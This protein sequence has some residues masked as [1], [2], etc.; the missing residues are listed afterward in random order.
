MVSR[1][2]RPGE[3]ISRRAVLTL[4][5]GDA[6]LELPEPLSAESVRDLDEWL[7]LVLRRYR[8]PGPVQGDEGWT[9]GG[10]GKGGEG[11]G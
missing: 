8:R 4:R 1:R 5:E 11:G 3:L 6:I 2:T 9:G 7:R 10:R